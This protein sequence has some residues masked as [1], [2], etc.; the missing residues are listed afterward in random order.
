MKIL[1]I[2][3]IVG[4]FI[5]FTSSLLAKCQTTFFT[6]TFGLYKSAN[7][8]NIENYTNYDNPKYL[9]KGIGLISRFGASN[10]CVYLNSNNVPQIYSSEGEY[11]DDNLNYIKIG[12]IFTSIY[13]NVSIKISVNW[14]NI[15]SK[16]ISVSFS[17]D[18]KKWTN[19]KYDPKWA[20]P[21][22]TL[23][24]EKIPSVNRLYIKIQSIPE[25]DCNQGSVLIDYVSLSGVSNTLALNLKYPPVAST[26]NSSI[27]IK[28]ETFYMNTIGWEVERKSDISDDFKKI[29][30]GTL[31]KI[32]GNTFY[33]K[34]YDIDPINGV[35][36]YRIK[37][38]NNSDFSKIFSAEIIKENGVFEIYYLDI[39][40]RK[41]PNI[42]NTSNSIFIE[43][44]NSI[45]KLKYIS[46]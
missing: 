15:K 41:I 20:S 1:V 30:N 28:W 45:P 13:E 21:F 12:P 11:E 27:V 42:E 31:Y 6:E 46:K 44:K 25:D 19:L 37:D 40:G 7:P 5:L 3:K 16:R 39:Y 23:V 32:E 10:G 34:C 17:T 29:G 26:Y 33:Y 14:K 35:N 2:K 36:I 8:T 22:D 43:V 24:F 18:D 4:F 9:F 38:L